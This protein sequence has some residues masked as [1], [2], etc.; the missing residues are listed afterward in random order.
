[1]GAVEEGAAV[2]VEAAH[3]GWRG[4]G[5]VGFEGDAGV[6]GEDPAVNE[7]GAFGCGVGEEEVGV[8]GG[9]SE[10]RGAGGGVA[11][12]GDFS[13][14]GVVEACVLGAG[15]AFLADD[16]REPWSGGEIDA[17]GEVPADGGGGGAATAGE[18]G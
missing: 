18:R 11:G 8:G 2:F 10:G 9:E 6:G 5:E 17:L 7:V 13:A 1:L 12:S 14:E 4:A 15:E 3:E 16:G